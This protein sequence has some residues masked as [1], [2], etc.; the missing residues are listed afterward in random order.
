MNDTT[1]SLPGWR[2]DGRTADRVEVS[3]RIDADRRAWLVA[4][5]AE[6]QAL[7]LSEAI[8]TEPFH[9]APLLM[10][11]ADGSHL[12]L[13]RSTHAYAALLAAGAKPAPPDGLAAS[14]ARDW[15]AAVLC[16][17]FLVAVIT[18]FYVW[19]LP[20]IAE[21]AVPM[22]P[23]AWK[24]AMGNAALEQLDKTVFAPSTLGQAKRDEIQA[25][26]GELV[27]GD[28]MKPIL[29][30]R[31]FKH[32]P[33]AL[34]LPGGH[35][36][37]TD[38]LVEF[39]KGDVNVLTGVLAHELGHVKHE[40]GL[41][42]VIQASALS[43]LGSALIGD[44]SSVLATAPAVLGQLHYSREFEAQADV[45]SHALLCALDFDPTRTAEFFDAAL[46]KEG[47][48]GEMVPT[49]L[50]SHPDSGKRA[51]FFRQKC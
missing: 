20:R 24:T 7:S 49:Y 30:F 14:L 25:R 27:E 8:L 51:Q 1:I 39:V 4:A 44:Y 21:A 45:H 15:R 48:V 47:V 12:E 5:N 35:V 29:H 32:G 19:L 46:K 26:F 33:N 23:A 31:H 41:R 34:A 17:L 22:V 6:P 40:H 43:I 11:Y 38:E 37:L 18:A 28:K 42:L 16:L 2:F 50:R 13:A 36:I 9:H 10:H 3:V